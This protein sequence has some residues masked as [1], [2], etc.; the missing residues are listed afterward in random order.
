MSA[1]ALLAQARD[2]W[3]GVFFGL[4]EQERFALLIVAIA[5]GTGVL[6]TAFVFLSNTIN[7]IHRRRV[8]AA[9]KREMIERGMSAEEIVS[10]I[11]AEP[12]LDNPGER[13]LA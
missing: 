7:G 11:E 3:S 1:L 12:P 6:C 2:E 10:I 9:L 4:G 8:A 5:C 13:M